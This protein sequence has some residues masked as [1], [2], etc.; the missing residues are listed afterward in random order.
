MPQRQSIRPADDQQPVRGSSAATLFWICL[1]TAAALYAPCVLAGRIVAWGDL[2]A[3]YLR[4]QAELVAN[5]Q[6]IRHL[7]RV[8]AALE[9]DPEFAEQVARAE[10]GAARAGTRVI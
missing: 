9:R 5:Q 3:A 6:Q 7:Q 4:N 8:A 2:Q 1:L 10:L